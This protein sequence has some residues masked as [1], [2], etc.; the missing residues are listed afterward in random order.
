MFFFTLYIE[1]KEQLVVGTTDRK[2]HSILFENGN[3]TITHVWNVKEQVVSLC[4]SYEV[5]SSPLNH[6]EYPIIVAGLQGGIYAR[7]SLHT[8]LTGV[9]YFGS[10]LTNQQILQREADSASDSSTDEQEA[11]S[12]FGG[13][14]ISF[15]SRVKAQK[16]SSLT[17]V[18][19]P[20][21]LANSSAIVCGNF[22]GKNFS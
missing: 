14:I 5:S 22:E 10:T 12:P 4:G 16:S 7:I 13:S 6:A 3:V 8:G 21:R 1:N 15:K 9:T 17:M 18:G 20:V 19:G 2:V 11:N